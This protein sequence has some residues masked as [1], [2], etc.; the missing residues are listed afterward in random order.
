MLKCVLQ[1]YLTRD[2][3]LVMP[4]VANR[5]AFLVCIIEDN[6]NSGFGDTSLTLFVDKFLQAAGSDLQQ[7]FG[8]ASRLLCL[9]WM[10]SRPAPAAADLLQVCDTKD[11]AD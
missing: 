1:Q 5:T 6:G 9:L 2:C 8:L 3:D 7:D 4:L 11:E 10:G